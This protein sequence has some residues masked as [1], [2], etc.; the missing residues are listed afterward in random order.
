VGASARIGSTG[1]GVL[2]EHVEVAVVIKDA[3]VEQFI[4]K[5]VPGTAAVRLH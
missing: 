5:L 4:L 1:L 3:G 2:H